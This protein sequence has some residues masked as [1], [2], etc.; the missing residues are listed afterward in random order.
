VFCSKSAG[1]FGEAERHIS[2]WERGYLGCLP[3][4]SSGVN[5]ALLM[6]ASQLGALLLTRFFGRMILEVWDAV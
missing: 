1:Y 2:S 4:V 5:P 6:P 3:D